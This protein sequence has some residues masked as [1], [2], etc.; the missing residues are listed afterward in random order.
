MALKKFAFKVLNKDNYSRLGLIETYR[1]NI[2]T[3]AFMPVGTQGTVKACTIDD[4]KKTGSE[5]ILGNTYHLMIRPGV[6]R[7]KRMGG[8]H[9]FMNCELPI[10]TDS[11]GFQIM[12]LGKNVK[13]DDE[14]VTFR[15]HLD[16]T[17]VRLNA[18]KSIEVQKCITFSR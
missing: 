13:V 4:I 8:L 7:I 14:G 18:E 16:G 3:P 12:S 17:A 6:E 9:E 15:S 2:Q 1:G 10:L 11:G 5:I